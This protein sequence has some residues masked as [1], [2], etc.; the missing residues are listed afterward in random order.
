MSYG[1]SY[2]D[3][4]GLGTLFEGAKSTITPRGDGT[5]TQYFVWGDSVVNESP[6]TAR[7]STPLIFDCFKTVK[8][9]P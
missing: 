2:Y 7:F 6:R 1:V 8:N 4:G 5:G 3:L 9:L